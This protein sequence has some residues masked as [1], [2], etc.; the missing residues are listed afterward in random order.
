MTSIQFTDADRDDRGRIKAPAR[1]L[2]DLLPETSTAKPSTAKPISRQELLSAG[3]VALL[4][5]MALLY[6]SSGQPAAPVSVLPQATAMIRLA[7]IAHP[8]PQATI[9]PVRM[10]DAFAAPEGLR[11][12]AIEATRAI[13][14]VAHFGADWIQADVKGSGRIWLRTRDWPSLAITG[15]NL[16]IAPGGAAAPDMAAMDSATPE[17]EEIRT[18]TK[19]A[20][21]RA[22]A[23]ALAVQ[24]EREQ[25]D[26]PLGNAAAQPAAPQ[27]EAEPSYI[28]NVGQQAP[29][30]PR[31]GLCGP[32]SGDC[33]PVPTA[34]PDMLTIIGQQAPH[35]VR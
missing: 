12:G 16:E 11:L 31:G 7:P 22:L 3:I 18:G 19:P 28:A 27:I 5:L 4:L 23:H 17:Q 30:V 9:A 15:D 29:H 14:P 32:T 10:L 25:H 24:Q 26:S 6:I 20:D 34:A 35:K 8:T 13:T 21:D 2:A 33:A 1:S